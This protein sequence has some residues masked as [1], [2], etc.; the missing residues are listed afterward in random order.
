MSKKKESGNKNDPTKVIILV[1]AIL[2]L[3]KTLI[4]FIRYLT[5]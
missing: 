5:E 1:T 2:N 3:V 4:E